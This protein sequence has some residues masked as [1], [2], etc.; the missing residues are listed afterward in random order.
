MDM[1]AARGVNREQMMGGKI[2][3]AKWERGRGG[4]RERGGTVGCK[5]KPYLGYQ[6]PWMLD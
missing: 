5:G 1:A 4:A 3:D 2:E 6:N